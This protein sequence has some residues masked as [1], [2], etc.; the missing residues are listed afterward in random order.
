MNRV[1]HMEHKVGIK[2]LTESGLENIFP[3]YRSLENKIEECRAAAGKR[4]HVPKK[5]YQ[6]NYMYDNVFSILGK[7][8]T[9]K[10]SAAFTL[11]ER[12]EN[13]K[14]HPEDVVLPIIIPEVIPEDCSILG[15]I[16]A[17]VK[18]EVERLEKR[19]KDSQSETEKDIY[20][21]TC[22]YS[23][24][25]AENSLSKKLNSLSQMFFAGKYN[26]ANENSYYK[27][28]ENS[29][30]QAEEYYQFAQKIA[31]LWDLWVDRLKNGKENACPLIYFIFDDV[32]L[33]PEKI[34]E[35]LSV[36]IKYLSHP[37]II[38]ITTADE[39]LFLEVTE[40][41]LDRN[42]GRLPKE[43]R[44]YLRHGAE[45]TLY[46]EDELEEKKKEKDVVSETAR[47]YLGKVMPPSTR[48]YLRLFHT[49]SQ[50]E[51]FLLE[52]L[53]NV[54]EESATGQSE[55]ENPLQTDK[56]HS[57][58]EGVWW[59][60][61]R[62]LAHTAEGIEP[63]KCFM[64]ERDRI[65]NFYLNFFGNTSRQI[66]NT[67][68]GI[69]NLVDNLCWEIRRVNE[70][71]LGRENYLSR[72]YEIC[73]YFIGQV[74]HTNHNL[75]GKIG[76][77]DEFVDEAFMT[78]YRGWKLYVNYAY[79]NEFLRENGEE[80]EQKNLNMGLQLF[81]LMAFVEN[82]LL[83]LEYCTD[84]GI[85]E[86]RRIN[87]VRHFAGFLN[88]EVF[89]GR[90]IFRDDLNAEI[91]FRQY[92]TLL[93][94][95]G[96]IVANRNSD[97]KLEVEF[98]YNLKD[99]TPEKGETKFIHLWRMYRRNPRWLREMIGMTAMVY[100]NAYLVNR[101]LMEACTRQGEDVC[102]MGYQTYADMALEENIKGY[103]SAFDLYEYAD[104][105]L[106]IVQWEDYVYSE[107]AHRDYLQRVA[108]ALRGMPEQQGNDVSETGQYLPLA[109]ILKYV[110]D[111]CKGADDLLEHCPEE[112]IDELRELLDGSLDRNDIQEM[113]QK[114][115][116]YIEKADGGLLAVSF[117]DPEHWVAVLQELERN[118]KSTVRRNVREVNRLIGWIFRESPEVKTVERIV[119]QLGADVVAK[120][121]ELFDGLRD[122]LREDKDA[123]ETVQELLENLDYAIDLENLT[124]T[125][126][127]I[128]RGIHLL[129]AQYL[130]GIYLSHYI[131]EAYD[132]GYLSAKNFQ[133]VSG[134]KEKTYYYKL[135]EIMKA[136][137]QDSVQV[138][139][140]MQKNKDELQRII[141]KITR[142]QRG[143]YID[144]L[145]RER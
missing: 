119:V 137:E 38:V 77:T 96:A 21:D 59:Q 22:R 107:E 42:I 93:D 92:T 52:E 65:V 94:R 79:L 83:I 140:S 102:R 139:K 56:I 138:T 40:N 104:R 80:D 74:I 127:A 99:E 124:Q 3:M 128:E 68:I 75:S 44:E 142:T 66:A 91:F 7:R 16:L 120:L 43:W 73:R 60:I 71:T 106:E 114:E 108:E 27:A 64:G 111:S 45:S 145:L 85:T 143:K 35:L 58:G 86:R 49:A 23:D 54:G 70:G 130:Q 37:N 1:E 113:L 32:D 28:V 101:S 4:Q 61:Q 5:H 117:Y 89:A 34:G 55:G 39:D 97:K 20:W 31:D 47:M 46:F 132:V 109:T 8:G 24:G 125:N 29:A 30:V 135:F 105:M 36:I 12:I 81:S 118:E 41:R 115:I 72:V 121:R 116:A 57:L 110:D 134:G 129:V 13:D 103:M 78:G 50:K 63:P 131:K 88:E 14:R 112:T 126:W 122:Y 144:Q 10:T 17:V 98:F 82:I 33:A 76:M 6:Y 90:Y 15:W 133:W 87:I 48:Y 136:T 51:R 53:Q 11:K 19:L 69:R 95:L 62:L 2:I 123:C 26:P 9:G 84:G 100:G 25:A 67:Y 141:K 18:E